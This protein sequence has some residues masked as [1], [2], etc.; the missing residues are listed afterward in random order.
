MKK[1][2]ITLAIGLFL[3]IGN[4]NAQ[5]IAQ[6]VAQLALDVQKLGQMKDILQDMYQA[7][8]IL[9]K[10]YTDIQNIVQG[11]F[12]LHKAFL[13]GLLAV[14]PTVKN[15]QRVVD[16]INT[17]YT[18]VSE[19]KTAYGQF[20]SG[21]HFTIQELDYLNTVYTNLFN[22]SLT[23]LNELVMVIT[24]NQLRM[25]DAERLQAIDR[26]YGDITGQLR[27]LRE[28]NNSTSVQAAMRARE[29][30]DIGTLKSMYGIGN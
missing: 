29:A 21:G 18:L 8:T 25:S 19:Y 27:L 3:V 17:E 1:Y 9:D 2:A 13:D 5:S 28:F 4:S 14:S 12:N 6:L 23:C 10:G 11:N 16:I 20:S 7:Y 15:Y 26:V 30:N 22:R 24:A